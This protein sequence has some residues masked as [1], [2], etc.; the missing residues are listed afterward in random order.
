METNVSANV[1]V[2][3]SNSTTGYLLWDVC[4]C[5]TTKPGWGTN[6]AWTADAASERAKVNSKL[7][8][9]MLSDDGREEGSCSVVMDGQTDGTMSGGN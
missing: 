7:R 9:R 2:V 3:T 8:F 4:S 1:V 6:S 5:R